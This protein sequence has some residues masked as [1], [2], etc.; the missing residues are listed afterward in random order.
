MKY[1][2]QIFKESRTYSTYIVDAKSK[3][4]ARDVAYNMFINDE[5]ANEVI[6][7][8]KMAKVIDITKQ[9]E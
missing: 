3:D 9:E 2:V 1:K 8:G 6:T 4:A 7:D 5:P